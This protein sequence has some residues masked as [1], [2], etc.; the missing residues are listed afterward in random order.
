MAHGVEA[1]SVSEQS[2]LL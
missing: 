1:Q 2:F